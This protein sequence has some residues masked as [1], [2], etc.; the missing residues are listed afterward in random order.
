MERVPIFTLPTNFPHRHDSTAQGHN[1]NINKH[2]YYTND[3]D[4]ST[5]NIQKM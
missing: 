4:S 1:I 2:C 5:N 3:H